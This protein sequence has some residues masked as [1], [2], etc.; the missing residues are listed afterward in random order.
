MGNFLILSPEQAAV[1]AAASGAGATNGGSKASAG[2]PRS[3]TMGTRHG[4]V[5]VFAF[6]LYRVSAGAGSSGHVLPS[7]L[8]TT[9]Q[10]SRTIVVLSQL[11]SW[12]WAWRCVKAQTG[13]ETTHIC[14]PRSLRL[15]MGRAIV[16]SVGACFLATEPLYTIRFK[17][18]SW[19]ESIVGVSLTSHCI[20]ASTSFAI[21]HIHI[22]YSP[23]ILLTVISQ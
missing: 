5:H 15:K 23:F 3:A 4:G 21:A 19:Y 2:Y 7:M 14:V 10:S 6:R 9:R 18:G 22:G 8:A 17:Y 11:R 13:R 1:A 20:S 16:Y 12:W